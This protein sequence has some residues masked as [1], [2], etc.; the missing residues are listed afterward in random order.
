M[1]AWSLKC[2]ALFCSGMTQGDVGVVKLQFDSLGIEF[3]R[4]QSNKHLT[5]F[6]PFHAIQSVILEQ[7]RASTLAS[8]RSRV[9]TSRFFGIDPSH[10]NAVRDDA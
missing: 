7:K 1:L 8:L 4:K 2:S 6:F 10:A 5:K 3:F 9:A